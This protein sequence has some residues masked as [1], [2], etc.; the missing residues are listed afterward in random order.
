MIKQLETVPHPHILEAQAG[1]DTVWAHA[2]YLS[3]LYKDSDQAL[4]IVDK[5][6]RVLAFNKAGNQVTEKLFNLT[7]SHGQDISPA[8]L[9]NANVQEA[10]QAAL[11]GKHYRAIRKSYSALGIEQEMLVNYAPIKSVDGEVLAVCFLAT[12]LQKERKDS[13]MLRTIFEVTDLAISLIDKNGYVVEAN[14]KLWEMGGLAKE[15]VVEKLFYHHLTDPEA[16]EAKRR[17]YAHTFATLQP[18]QVL[19]FESAAQSKDGTPI[20][21]RSTITML[22]L[23][24]EEPLIFCATQN[25]TETHRYKVLMKETE[26]MAGVGGWEYIPGNKR[27]LWTEGLYQLLGFPQDMVGKHIAMETARAFF[28]AE[29]LKRI[30]KGFRQL[31]RERYP[32]ELELQLHTHQGERKWVRY[33]CQAQYTDGRITRLLGIVKDID[34]E[35][36][37]LQLLAEKRLMLQ[38]QHREL[39]KA[40]Y[41]MDEFTYRT[42]HDLRA[43]LS[44]LRGLLQLAQK[45]DAQFVKEEYLPRMAET[46]D[47]MEHLLGS[48]SHFSSN[49]RN[50][51]R[52]EPLAL[53]NLLEMVMGKLRHHPDF[54]HIRWEMDIKQ[55]YP[56]NGDTDRLSYVLYRLLYNAISYQDKP[57]KRIWVHALQDGPRMEIEIG[58]NG[59]GFQSDVDA[60]RMFF[61]GTERTQG[62]GLSLYIVKEMVEK[63]HGIIRLESRKGQGSR[64][65]LTL[66]DLAGIHPFE[67]PIF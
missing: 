65:L 5:G 14:S 8:L 46:L 2:D 42:S 16:R 57:E 25:V 27:L 44:T 15:E 55:P 9:I 66:P 19:S 1:M 6:L 34:Q 43:P 67:M 21:L 7:L 61:R 35:R 37:S 58:D 28:P 26:R 38:R 40:Y 36:K 54:G 11:S 56:F 3:F 20:D 51:L 24:G 45:E 33:S 4:I 49:L 18:G 63:M 31:I 62:A 12:L 22:T 59:E 48:V 47:K 10:I 64:F 41:E 52:H 23:P 30:R 39:R 29:S 17:Q 32:M 13:A 53:S 50:T 60:F